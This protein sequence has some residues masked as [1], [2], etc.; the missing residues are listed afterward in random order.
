MKYKVSKIDI[1]FFNTPAHNCFFVSLIQLKIKL[2][3]HRVIFK[4]FQLPGAL[5][6]KN[7]YSEKKFLGKYS[8]LF[9]IKFDGLFIDLSK[10]VQSKEKYF[11]KKNNNNSLQRFHYNHYNQPSFQKRIFVQKNKFEPSLI[12]YF[13]SLLNLCA[14]VQKQKESEVNYQYKRITTDPK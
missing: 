8:W 10:T 6:V 5:T 12:R 3:L 1:P 11:H 14:E 7:I 13:W 9:Y 2:V 4:M